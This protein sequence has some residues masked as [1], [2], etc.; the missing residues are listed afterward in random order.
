MEDH[1]YVWSAVDF[2]TVVAI[3]I[4]VVYLSPFVVFVLAVLS[5]LF[6]STGVVAGD[7]IVIVVALVVITAV[8]F[9]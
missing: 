6:L 2:V 4:T 1:A 5:F 3:A 8:F 7:F 9:C